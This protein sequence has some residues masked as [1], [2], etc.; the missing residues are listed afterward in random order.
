MSEKFRV[1]WTTLQLQPALG[2]C[3]T[4]SIFNTWSL[5]I[6]HYSSF[7]KIHSDVTVPVIF[8]IQVLSLNCIADLNHLSKEMERM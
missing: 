3:W 5:A 8:V 6:K 7:D 1:C 2:S 4:E